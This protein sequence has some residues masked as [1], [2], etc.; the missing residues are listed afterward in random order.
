MNE[1]IVTISET[2]ERQIKVSA[3]SWTEAT[4]FVR[5]QYDNGETVLGADDFTRV[6][7]HAE[8]VE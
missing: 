7:F 1:Y 2:L 8:V 5:N 6:E 3:N 4:G